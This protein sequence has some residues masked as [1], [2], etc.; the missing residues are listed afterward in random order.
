MRDGSYGVCEV[1][2]KPIKKDRLLAVPFAR[3]SIEGQ[4]EFEKNNRRKLNREAGNLFGDGDETLKLSSDDD[5][6]E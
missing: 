4:K 3:F 1:T 5:G 2:G 6:E